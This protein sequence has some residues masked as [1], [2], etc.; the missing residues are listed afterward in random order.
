MIRKAE[1][2]RSPVTPIQTVY[3]GRHAYIGKTLHG[4]TKDESL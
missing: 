2:L 1:G 4:P 3:S